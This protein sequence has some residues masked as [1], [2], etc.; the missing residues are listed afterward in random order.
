MAKFNLN[1]TKTFLESEGHFMNK[2]NVADEV[3]GAAKELQYG[4]RRV[5]YERFTSYAL[6]HDAKSSKIKAKYLKETLTS[7][8]EI[9]ASD[10]DKAFFKAYP[11]FAKLAAAAAK[12]KAKA[13]A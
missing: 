9:P 3:I 11:K 5:W 12:N 6:K 1:E 4:K 2:G 10:Y 13:T 7:A 8:L